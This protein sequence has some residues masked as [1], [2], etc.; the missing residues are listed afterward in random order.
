[1]NEFKSLN[2]NERKAK[3]E[4]QDREEFGLDEEV[5]GA[6]ADEIINK[7]EKGASQAFEAKEISKAATKNTLFSRV[8]SVYK[9]KLKD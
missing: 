8:F 6:D 9:Q 4:R 3:Q 5:A 2:Q 7:E 1:M